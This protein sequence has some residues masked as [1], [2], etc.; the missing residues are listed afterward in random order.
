MPSAIAVRAVA[1]IA[2]FAIMARSV[3]D[4]DGSRPT[5]RNLLLARHSAIASLVLRQALQSPPNREDLDL[6]D[7][8]LER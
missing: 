3:F 6:E 4:N 2:V 5:G 7:A 1:E 8:R